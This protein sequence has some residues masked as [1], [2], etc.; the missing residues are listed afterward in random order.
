MDSKSGQCNYLCRCGD[1][2]KGMLI[3]NSIL[4]YISLNDT[5]LGNI[6]FQK[7][8]D[9]L[10]QNQ[11]LAILRLSKNKLNNCDYIIKLIELNLLEIDLSRNNLSEV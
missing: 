3:K 5:K 2:I 1:S 10:G 8:I 7:I 9:G 6:A 4:T 11:S